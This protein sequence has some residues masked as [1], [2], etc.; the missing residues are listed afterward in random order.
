MKIT[1]VN[2]ASFIFEY[3]G[4]KLITDPWI[5]STAFDNGWA[6]LSKSKMG[7]ED[8]S[9]ITHIWFSH[10][11]PD[12][13]S[14]PCLNKIT[15]NDR[16]KITVLFQSTCDRKVV[17]YCKKAGFATIIEMKDDHYYPLSK[18]TQCLC[19]PHSD[20]DS[21]LY[22]KTDTYNLLNVNDCVIENEKSAI[23]IKNKIGNVDVLFTQF[24]YAN[25]IGNTNDIER[26]E[27]ESKEKL[28]RI[29]IQK[30]I[31]QPK[32]I[33][34]FAS[35]VYFCHE[36]NK[37][38]NNGMNKIDTVTNF[39]TNELK[40]N[41][42]VL[43]PG[44]EWIVESSYNNTAAINSYLSDHLKI[45]TNEAVFI[46]SNARISIS[47]LVIESNQ[48][49][50]NLIAYDNTN[51]IYKILPSAKI[52]IEDYQKSYSFNLKNGLKEAIYKTSECDIS[53]KSEALW[54]SFKYLWGGDTLTINARF[55]T[56]V[57]GNFLNM[58]AYYKLAL[59]MNRGEKNNIK[60]IIKQLVKS[61]PL[62]GFIS[63]LYHFVR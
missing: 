28:R 11:H 35:Y 20:G 23:N 36:E 44:D 34:P 12:H 2:H 9:K 3:D 15:K 46:P 51:K 59:K 57:G 40:T 63:K 55:Q 10:E 21:W 52:W 48:F 37:Y 27:L 8:F 7:Y 49:I 50:K 54:Y 62:N 29:K 41:A 58:R 45:D 24:G 19:N 42:I 31:F 13:F 22:I 32:T 4:I 61:S 6:L 16:S 60:V 39:I 47:D 25:K 1:W 26:R 14:P 43:Y 5:E 30:N 38:M 56:P 17:E 18:N 33:I 53:L